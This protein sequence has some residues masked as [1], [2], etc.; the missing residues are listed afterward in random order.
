MTV[1]DQNSARDQQRWLPARMAFASNTGADPGVPPIIPPFAVL[2][3]VGSVVGGRLSLG[4]QELQVARPYSTDFAS[5]PLCINGPTRFFQKPTSGLIAN[6]SVG[7]VTMDYPTYAL[8]DVA[9]G[10]PANGEIWG[11]ALGSFKLRKGNRGFK[12]IGGATGTGDRAIVR[13]ERDGK[14]ET[15]PYAAAFRVSLVEI[16]AGDYVSPMADIYRD[17]DNDGSPTGV[18]FGASGLDFSISGSYLVGFSGSIASNTAPRGTLLAM[19]LVIKNAA[20]Q[21]QTTQYTALR[22][23]DIESDQYG[24]NILTTLENIAT[25]GPLQIRA[26][27]TLRLYNQ[28]NYSIFFTPGTLFAVLLFPHDVADFDTSTPSPDPVNEVQQIFRTGVT[29]LT[30]T[31]SF[32]GQITAAIDSDADAATLQAALEALSTIGA[33]NVSVTLTL[34]GTAPDPQAWE[35]EFIG[36]LGGTNVGLLSTVDPGFSVTVIT[37]GG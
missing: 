10:V 26:G 32:G 23:Q 31:V 16:E 20:D 17:P 30:F 5:K 22:T 8:Y 6:L 35:V 33:D 34:D 18:I 2:Q 15:H 7:S 36:T 1:T 28:S 4:K 37:E 21:T 11:P 3:I 14:I 27:W 25:S 9:D 24:D 13:V 19:G 12:I 29:P